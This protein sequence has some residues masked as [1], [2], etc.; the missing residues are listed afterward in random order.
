MT[1]RWQIGFPSPL[2]QAS[3]HQWATPFL[4]GAAPPKAPPD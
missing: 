2:A 4:N 1:A 3:I